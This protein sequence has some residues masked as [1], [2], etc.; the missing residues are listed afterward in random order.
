[1]TS[2]RE[3]KKSGW[4]VFRLVAGGLSFPPLLNTQGKQ[5]DVP[6][7]AAAEETRQATLDLL[8]EK[9]WD[10]Q[11]LDSIKVSTGF[12]DSSIEDLLWTQNR[13]LEHHDNLLR[14]RNLIE[15]TNH[16][17]HRSKAMRAKVSE[18]DGMLEEIAI[19]TGKEIGALSKE[20]E[21]D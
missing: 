14:T 21:T 4:K 11:T 19:Q 8:N 2:R 10:I 17:L 7:R 20:K 18:V 12:L 6:S 16:A 15:K 13:L 3:E 9:F 5:A 1:M